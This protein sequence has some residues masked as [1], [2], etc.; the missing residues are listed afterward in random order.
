MSVLISIK[1]L[2]KSFGRGILFDDLTFNISEGDRVGLTGLNG[3]GK[4]TLLKILSG[5]E[6]A[7]SGE[8][9]SRK[10]LRVG[11]VSQ[12]CF[13][14]N[15][16]PKEILMEAAK[17]VAPD[18]DCER[19]AD[20]QLQKFLFTGN[21]VSAEALS[22]GWK[23]RL[24]IAVELIK[25]PD[26]LLLDEPTNHLDLEGI[27]WLEGFLK[28]EAVAYLLVSHDRYFLQHATNRIIEI[29]KMYP[30][31]VFATDGPYDEF[32]RLK[33][34]FMEGQIEQE[35]RI[36]N[37]LRRETE[38]LRAG[39]KART[40]KADF[41]I[42]EAQRIKEEHAALKQ[43]NTHTHTKID[44]ESSDRETRKLLVAK[45][46]SK[47]MGGRTL[48]KN[49][50]FTLS[51]GSRIGLMG[52]NGCGKTTLLSMIEGKLEPDQ[53]T[54]KRAENLK[55]VYFDQHRVNLPLHLSLKDALAPNGDYV[56]FRGRQIHINAW[57]KRFLFDPTLLPTPI[58][59]L[60]GGERARINIAHLML[61]PA[62]ILLLD[63]PTN[64]LDIPTLETLEESLMDFPGA[65]V[66]ISH[67]RYMLDRICNQI[68]FLGDPEK[69][70]M[71]AD[72][73]QW[74]SS[75]KKESAPKKSEK[76]AAAAK[77][78]EPRN[79]KKEQEKIEKKISKLEEMVQ[80]LHRKIE[81][82]EI[83]ENPKRLSELC[84]EVG[85]LET[86]ITELYLK[87]EEL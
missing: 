6:K 69:A 8:I 72:Y 58:G 56:T 60:S 15:K 52:P 51:P 61:Q 18:Y 43:R 53:G 39:V 85:L 3:C 17:A 22:G 63:E 44:F 59:K 82:K 29:D 10:G 19:I 74:V 66:L 80:T 7:D 77:N 42:D 30:S 9:S 27:V 64:D 67:D 4:S 49:L 36:A 47:D 70:L 38:W 11:Y 37:K 78:P 86:Q 1:S 13:F 40:T 75:Q 79:V 54:V 31:G 48:F 84:N 28:K 55:I 83:A 24:S 76:V 57:A 2:A 25:E 12:D 45:N 68:V 21:E 32:L 5:L 71:F 26:L 20:M 23:K 34:Q 46:V 65:L 41:R 87:W 62:D 73:A 33:A 81:T 14:P 35:K 50:E 16:S